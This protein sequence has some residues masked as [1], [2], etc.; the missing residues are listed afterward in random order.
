MNT[1]SRCNYAFSYLS[2]PADC[3]LHPGRVFLSLVHNSI[4]KGLVWCLAQRRHLVNTPWMNIFLYA[5]NMVCSYHYHAEWISFLAHLHFYCAG[6]EP[7]LS[8]KSWF[9]YEFLLASLLQ[10]VGFHQPGSIRIATTPV[11]VDEF[12]YQMTRTRW[13]ATEQYIIE[14]EKIQEMFPLLNMNKVF[15]LRA[16][17]P[18]VNFN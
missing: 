3:K 9:T 17:S 6:E 10:V 13:H 16:F 11:R 4:S 14:P 18:F 2:L 8:A 7:W 1:I 12:K 15:I 5:A